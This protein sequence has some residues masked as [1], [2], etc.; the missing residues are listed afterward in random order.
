MGERGDRL[1]EDLG[2]KVGELRS[3]ADSSDIGQHR[4]G[5]VV[6][7]LQL[8][9]DGPWRLHHR[10]SLH[11]R[12]RFIG[13]LDLGHRSLIEPRRLERQPNHRVQ[14]LAGVLALLR[15]KY[16][17]HGQPKMLG[18]DPEHQREPFVDDRQQHAQDEPDEHHSDGDFDQLALSHVALPSA[19][20]H[21]NGTAPQSSSRVTSLAAVG[22]MSCDVFLSRSFRATRCGRV[23]SAQ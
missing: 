19:R 14:E 11:R 7:P 17:A 15:S 22:R 23:L 2:G 3:S 4:C 6:E 10:T 20:E 18:P 13:A 8:G 1:G 5:G 12:C 9:L 16:A 21:G